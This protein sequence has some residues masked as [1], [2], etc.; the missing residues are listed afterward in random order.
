MVTFDVMQLYD[1]VTR[2]LVGVSVVHLPMSEQ[3]QCC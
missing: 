1:E 2:T 3:E